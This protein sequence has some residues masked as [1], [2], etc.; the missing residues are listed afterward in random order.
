MRKLLN[1]PRFVGLLAAAAV[2]FVVYSVWP[3]RTRTSDVA[4]NGNERMVMGSS[5][6]ETSPTPA[7]LSPR[8]AVK[9][10]VVP[11]VLRDPFRARAVAP[12][13]VTVEKAKA[14]DPTESVNVSAVWVQGNVTYALI[15][16]RVY[17]VGDHIG[18]LILESANRDGIW[19]SHWKGRDFVA[20]GGA[21]TLATPVQQP[22]TVA[23][24]R[25]G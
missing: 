4:V 2:I 23:L 20:V 1:N 12:P 9:E 18:G 22:E 16:R 8:A 24:S 6:Q 15:N 11:A 7:R 14:P 19:L 21:F 25:E 3:A 13:A 17:Q 5:L 10:L